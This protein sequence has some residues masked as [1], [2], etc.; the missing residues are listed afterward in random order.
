VKTKEEYKRTTGTEKWLELRKDLESIKGVSKVYEED[1]SK[2][3]G[4]KGFKGYIVEDEHGNS[5]KFGRLFKVQ[6]CPFKA[7]IEQRM[8]SYAEDG[9]IEP[10]VKRKAANPT[11]YMTLMSLYYQYLYS[12]ANHSAH[13]SLTCIIGHE[14]YRMLQRLELAKKDNLPN[15]FL[16]EEYK[17]RFETFDSLKRDVRI[18]LFADKKYM[19]VYEYLEA[20]YDLPFSLNKDL[21]D[22]LAYSIHPDAFWPTAEDIKQ[23][24]DGKKEEARKKAELWEK[25][26]PSLKWIEIYGTR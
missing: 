10:P 8:E 6:I 9:L 19:E 15:K 24:V 26:K 1:D 2:W 21:C 7:T 13:R 11:I 12:E 4:T 23:Y 22:V 3:F 18:G 17:K 16:I 5:W 25:N 14:T 20:R